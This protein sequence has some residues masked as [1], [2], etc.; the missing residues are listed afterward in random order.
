[1]NC[2]LGYEFTMV[3]IVHMLKLNITLH[4]ITSVSLKKNKQHAPQKEA[5]LILYVASYT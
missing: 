4:G 1:M 3:Y 2:K 5:Y